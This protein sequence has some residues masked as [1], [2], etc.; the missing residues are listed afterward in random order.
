MK[1][2]HPIIIILAAIVLGSLSTAGTYYVLRTDRQNKNIPTVPIQAQQNNDNSI[3][4]IPSRKNT[5]NT[6]STLDRNTEIEAASS[7]EIYSNDKYGFSLEYP[8]SW[9]LS[10]EEVDA[11]LGYFL[12]SIQPPNTAELFMF[13]R[14]IMGLEDT[15]TL[16]ETATTLGGLDARNITLSD[17]TTKKTFALILLNKKAPK[18]YQNYFGSYA[19]G[20]KELVPQYKKI[21][22][23]ITFTK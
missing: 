1:K 5:K 22:E 4:D 7:L 15:E 23:S 11:D 20:T 6:E 9:E 2:N 12:V 16:G 10:L 14:Q 3:I 19:L 21:I 13:G 17:P 18:K 8:E